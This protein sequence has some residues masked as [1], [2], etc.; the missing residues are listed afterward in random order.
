MVD[1]TD[2][3]RF[4][5]DKRIANQQ[6]GQV[7][8]DYGT[9]PGDPT[10][11]ETPAGTHDADDWA[12]V[13]GSI[14][15]GI[16]LTERELELVSI[17]KKKKLSME[18][19][20]SNDYLAF[21]G[22]PAETSR[23]Q[24]NA[25]NAT[26]P[27]DS[28][29]EFGTDMYTRM[30]KYGSNNKDFAELPFSERV[31]I[32]RREKL[33]LTTG[34][35]WRIKGTQ[36]LGDWSATGE[37][38]GQGLH[39]LKSGLRTMESL[40]EKGAFSRDGY[41]PEVVRR[42][43]N[44]GLGMAQ[45]PFG[46]LGMAMSPLAQIGALPT[47]IAVKAGA[48]KPVADAIGLAAEL[49]ITGG[50]GKIAT[51]DAAKNI[52]THGLSRSLGKFFYPTIKPKIPKGVKPKSET[53]RLNEALSE[54]EFPTGDP[55]KRGETYLDTGFEYTLHDEIKDITERLLEDRA[56]T[57]ETGRRIFLQI[58]D[59]LRKG[60]IKG[61]V[62][63]KAIEHIKDLAKNEG[64][65][66]TNKE[67]FHQIS[68]TWVKELSKAASISGRLSEVQKVAKRMEGH[69][70]E[71]LA[72]F[73]SKASKA[74]KGSGFLG[75]GK[76]WRSLGN[77]ERFRRVQLV[78]QLATA[79]RNFFVQGGM[80][81]L[82]MM[83]HAVEGAMMSMTGTKPKIAFQNI[84]Q[85][86]IQIGRSIRPSEHRKLTKILT[87]M[88]SQKGL[89]AYDELQHSMVLHAGLEG[90]VYNYMLFFN[91]LQETFFKRWAYQSALYSNLRKLKLEGTPLR[92]GL[93]ADM[94]DLIKMKDF[95]TELRNL[96][97]GSSLMKY[98]HERAIDHAGRMT[99][100]A[101]PSTAGGQIALEWASKPLFTFLGHAFPR[102]MV[103]SNK[104]LF[105]H[106]PAGILRFLHPG[107]LKEIAEA[108]RPSEEVAK[109]LSETL[110]GTSI[111]ATVAVFSE[112]DYGGTGPN[113]HYKDFYPD[114]KN[115]PNKK[116][117]LYPYNPLV[118]Y[119]LIWD[120]I[121]HPERLS[122]RDYIEGFL[123]VSRVAGTGIMM[124]DPLYK[125]YITPDGKKDVPRMKK[126][127]EDIAG[128]Y[129]EGMLTG[130]KDSAALLDYFSKTIHGDTADFE[131][132]H[133]PLLKSGPG[134]GGSTKRI[135]QIG[136]RAL[137]IPVGKDKTLPQALDT[138]R[139]LSIFESG[140]LTVSKTPK[141]QKLR[142]IAGVKFITELEV[143]KEVKRLKIPVLSLY[144]KTGV[145]ELDRLIIINMSRL[146]KPRIGELIERKEY[147]EAT[148]LKD[149]DV[150]RKRW[151]KGAI[152]K[153]KSDSKKSVL[154]R[155]PRLR[156][157]LDQVKE[158]KKLRK[159]LT[160]A[161]ASREFGNF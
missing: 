144:P 7:D 102:F 61:P 13:R 49:L 29:Q 94:D 104:M 23:E 156:K 97:Q 78:T 21:D 143:E 157:Q 57:F 31:E 119:R 137:P 90:K 135:L 2:E 41:L 36:A 110:V 11:L 9:S 131:T 148:G 161:Q 5:E 12:I 19:F 150:K 145:E 129:L 81:G 59:L 151:L 43:V 71:S 107:K 85:D 63:K 64:V 24:R 115:H 103:N 70:P 108:Q 69:I 52:A 138:P 72:P 88:Q 53:R 113:K 55:A 30:M 140:P 25:F 126:M 152:L 127:F 28:G 120:A 106:S 93:I 39:H 42:P 83:D 153:L 76:F 16:D 105:N 1:L 96:Y 155:S 101:K 26:F 147:K 136:T 47:E 124:L 8:S 109:I 95:P 86:F 20:L 17:A 35:S 3:E 37:R 84:L 80:V 130:V 87:S 22:R 112:T 99:F 34:E 15:K 51:T 118:T 125:N 159:P 6:Q 100:T 65:I 98:A 45:A 58:G 46:V 89:T 160:Q 56:I 79:S 74:D 134:I 121:F 60:E 149:G 32:L 154:S 158:E 14:E 92:P 33:P 132:K 75:L 10:R 50:A 114:P 128:K 111:L 133:K 139:A 73:L 4:A 18:E 91:R 68:K 66:L 48:P 82:N 123:G 54:Y 27:T 117:D 146:M 141:E 67:A 142:K 62:I 122:V 40:G 44:Y 38:F 77:I 116:I